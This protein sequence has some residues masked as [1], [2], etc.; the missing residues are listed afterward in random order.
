MYKGKH[1]DLKIQIIFEV[2]ISKTAFPQ[3][4]HMENKKYHT[5][6]FKPFLKDFKEEKSLQKDNFFTYRKER[7]NPCRSSFSP[8]IGSV[9]K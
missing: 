6:I 2:V 5:C 1:G 9:M 3:Q 7:K 4:N 8:Q